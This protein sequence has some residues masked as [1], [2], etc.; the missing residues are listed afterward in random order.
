VKG[1]SRDVERARRAAYSRPIEA[2]CAASYALGVLAV[3]LPLLATPAPAGAADTGRLPAVVTLEGVAGVVPFMT[4]EQMRRTWRFRFPTLEGGEPGGG[5][6]NMEYGALCTPTQ[7]GWA[8]FVLD[9]LREITF[10]RATRTDRGVGIGSTRAE[11]RRAYG[12]LS[13]VP[14]RYGFSS[15]L[16]V[17]ARHL[18]GVR[19][20]GQALIAIV[21][22]FSGGRVAQVRFGAS[23]ALEADRGDLTGI[24]C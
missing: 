11:L 8:V 19:K 7:R 18:P 2:S 21:F 17:L 10:T 20:E 6:A 16:K 3:V 24:A 22:E 14:P 4:A 12:K 5:G 15:A 1:F 13:P 23:D 9:A